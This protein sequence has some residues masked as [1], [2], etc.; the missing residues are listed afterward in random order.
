MTSESPELS[1]DEIAFR[2]VTAHRIEH[3]RG[4]QPDRLAAMIAA[5]IQQERSSCDARVREAERELER[6]KRLLLWAAQQNDGTLLIP[7]DVVR[8]NPPFEMRLEVGE[9]DQQEHIVIRAI[10]ESKAKDRP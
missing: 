3:G 4:P 8:E 1:P 10:P 2:L 9:D 7:L 5:A 6:A